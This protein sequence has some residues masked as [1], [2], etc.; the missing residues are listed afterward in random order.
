MRDEP[1]IAIHLRQSVV[2]LG[3]MLLTPS[4]TGG[5]QD[6][7]HPK[8]SSSGARPEA[9][10]IEVEIV[11]VAT[12]KEP[13][14]EDSYR[15]VHGPELEFS[16][17]GDLPHNV[18]VRMAVNPTASTE[19]SLNLWRD[20]EGRVKADVTCAWWGDRSVN[21]KLPPSGMLDDLGGKI[22]IDRDPFESPGLL[23]CR[24]ML[25]GTNTHYRSRVSVMGGF[26]IVPADTGPR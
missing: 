22:L 21:G 7:A 12:S 5:A 14:Y 24:F 3:L 8:A 11:Q 15:H 26:Q 6:E 17:H 9:T 16:N 25:T 18:R 19:T 2:A 20:E 1:M 4:F 10:P 13:W 23:R